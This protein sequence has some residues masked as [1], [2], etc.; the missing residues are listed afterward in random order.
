MHHQL[1]LLSILSRHTFVISIVLLLCSIMVHHTQPCI[2]GAWFS[3]EPD[4]S[5]LTL[6]AVHTSSEESLI[7]PEVCIKNFPISDRVECEAYE[8]QLLLCLFGAFVVMRTEQGKVDGF[9]IV[10]SLYE[11]W[12]SAAK[13]LRQTSKL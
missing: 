3:S 2:S 12:L 6:I 9:R 11:K 7:F 1:H 4:T 10:V 13:S 8:V 5:L